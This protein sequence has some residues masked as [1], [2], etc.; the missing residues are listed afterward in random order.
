MVLASLGIG[1][2]FGTYEV[3]VVAFTEA[4]A[5]PGTAGL[6]LGLWAVGSMIGGLFFGARHWRIDLPRQVAILSGILAV[7]LLVAPFVRSVPALALSATLGAF[8]VAP[9]LIAVFSLTER[10]VPEDQLTEGLTWTN[11]GLAVGYSFGTAVNGFVIDSY[12]TTVAFLLPALCAGFACLVTVAGLPVLR[13]SMRHG[14][15]PTPGI[16]LNSEAVP[17]PSPGGI[18]DDPDSGRPAGG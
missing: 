15:A 18:V 13:R 9:S 4:S 12:G 1:A 6:V 2:V 8:V 10:L 11:S 3:T 17:G 7:A 14:A 5:M 16:A